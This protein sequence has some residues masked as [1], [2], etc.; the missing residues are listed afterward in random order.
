MKQ[1]LPVV[2]CAKGIERAT[3]LFMTEIV[4]ETLPGAMPAVLSGPSF[5]EDVA[6]GLPTAVVLAATAG[7]RRRGAGGGAQLV[8]RSASIT[9][10][11]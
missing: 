8:V 1:G 7:A 9:A 10:P 3:G 11:T 5:A 6:R 2:I 4:A